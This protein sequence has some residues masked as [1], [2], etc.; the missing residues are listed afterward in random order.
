MDLLEKRMKSRFSHTTTFCPSLESHE[1]CIE[2]IRRVTTLPASFGDPVFAGRLT[3]AMEAILRNEEFKVVLANFTEYDTSPRS[4]LRMVGLALVHL[5]PQQPLP[6]VQMFR[7]ALKVSSIDSVKL[8]VLDLSVL[9]L[10]LLVAMKRLEDRNVSS[11]NFEAVY[12]EYD[13]FVRVSASGC[14][15]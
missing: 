14:P 11:Y 6:T 8:R 1:Q 13:N 2:L 7:Q 3:E 4:L 15:S 10:V 9:E 12:T 5:S